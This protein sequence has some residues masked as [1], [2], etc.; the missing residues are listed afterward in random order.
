MEEELLAL[1]STSMAAA[2]RVDS[3]ESELKIEQE[4]RHQMQHANSSD[5]ERLERARRELATMKKI[6]QEGAINIL[7]VTI[8]FM[9]SLLDRTSSR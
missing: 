4:C 3:V 2:A 8:Y 5:R 6:Q 7:Q 9:L 1:K